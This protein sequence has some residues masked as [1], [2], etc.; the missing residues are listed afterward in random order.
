MR[1]CLLCPSPLLL[2]HLFC[3]D[4]LCPPTHPHNAHTSIQQPP[5]PPTPPTCPCSDQRLYVQQLPSAEGGAPSEPRPLTAAD[6]KLR[7]ADGDVDESRNRRAGLADVSILLLL[8]PPSKDQS[9]APKPP[10]LAPTQSPPPA[11]WCVWWKITA[12]LARQSPP[13]ALLI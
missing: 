9:I 12:V 5:A 4:H 11:G 7:F 2:I 6:S 1:H 8:L 10:T 3:S 13:S